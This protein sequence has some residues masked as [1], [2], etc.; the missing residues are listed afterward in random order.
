MASEHDAVTGGFVCQ[1]C[2]ATRRTPLGI[3]RHR[4]LAHRGGDDT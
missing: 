4:S 1:E 2:G 3:E